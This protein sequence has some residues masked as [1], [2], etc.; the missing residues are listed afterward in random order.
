ME[1][2]CSYGLSEFSISVDRFVSSSHV[3]SSYFFLTH[4]HTDHMSGLLSKSK[5]ENEEI[6]VY[7]SIETAG[8]LK[9]M[10]GFSTK[11]K[12]RGLILR[13]WYSFGT[14]FDVMLIPTDHCIGSVALLFKCYSRGTATHEYHIFSGDFRYS[15][16]W[17]NKE[18]APV[19]KKIKRKITTLFIDNT[20]E[21]VAKF[22][23]WKETVDE[24]CVRASSSKNKTVLINDSKFNTAPLWKMLVDRG[25]SVSVSDE[26]AA[27]TVFR[28]VPKKKNEKKKTNRSSFL[29]VPDGTEGGV[30]LTCTWFVCRESGSMEPTEDRIC[31]STHSD[32]LEINEFIKRIGA[33]KIYK[34]S[35]VVSDSCRVIY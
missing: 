10:D 30:R 11:F 33:K 4:A 34:C 16:E 17:Y 20:F 26:L 18:M 22:P 24:L 21:P 31:F 9:T 19:M 2:V 15:R 3:Q 23:T 1:S 5:T 14:L 8:F 35:E 25:F 32:G 28:V 13:T 27:R 7:C 29:I 6:P 12:P